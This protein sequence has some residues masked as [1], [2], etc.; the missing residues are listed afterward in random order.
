MMRMVAA[1][2][3]VLGLGLAWAAAEEIG[4]VSTVFHFLSPDHKIVV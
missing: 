2:L 1:V 4:E 3:V